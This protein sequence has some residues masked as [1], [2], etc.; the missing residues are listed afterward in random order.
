MFAA[1]VVFAPCIAVAA[2]TWRY[3]SD[4]F[5]EG[6]GMRLVGSALWGLVVGSPISL[7]VWLPLL[8]VL[9]GPLA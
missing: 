3:R 2:W 9:F 6:P 5:A 1:L 8:A 4:E 7:V